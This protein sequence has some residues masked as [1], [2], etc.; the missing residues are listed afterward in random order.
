M[1]TQALYV[2]TGGPVP[3]F[4]ASVIPVEDTILLEDNRIKL[5]KTMAPNQ[6]IRPLG[7]DIAKGQ[8]VLEKYSTLQ[9][10]EIGLLASV[11]HTSSIKI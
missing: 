9:A 1:K 3:S 6:F 10:V 8:T 2:T 4:F 11:G 7:S 5:S